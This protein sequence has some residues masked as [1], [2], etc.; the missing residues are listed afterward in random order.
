MLCTGFESSHDT[1]D[2]LDTNVNTRQIPYPAALKVTP[3]W[4]AGIK[5]GF[6]VGLIVVS[7]I[8]NG[9]VLVTVGRNRSMRTT[10]NYYLVNLAVCDLIVTVFCTWVH[11]VDDLTDGWVLGAVFCKLSSFIQGNHQLYTK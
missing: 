1:L 8:G 10:T 2:N 6:Y 5:I 9:L 3:P 4:E 7:V 11:L